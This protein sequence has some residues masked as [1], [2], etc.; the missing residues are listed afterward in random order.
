VQRSASTV[1]CLVG[2]V[3]DRLRAVLGTHTTYL[4]HDDDPLGAVAEAWTRLFEESGPIGELEVAAAETI[5]RWRAA[6][7]ELPDYYLVTGI[8]DL[9]PTRRHWY[10]GVLH[11]AAPNRVVP[12]DPSETAV[13]D[14]LESLEPGPWWPPL[15]RLL[16][17]IETRAPEPGPIGLALGSA[18]RPRIV[19]PA[20][21]AAGPP[22]AT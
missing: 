20:P 11:T 1:V 12:V 4:L 16:D 3:P 8:D 13:L 15:D 6:S 14:A 21:R 17:G 22:V 10:F 7:I 19:T 5:A 9:G 2:I 18:G